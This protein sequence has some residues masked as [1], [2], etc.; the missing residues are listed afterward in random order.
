MAKYFCNLNKEKI[1]RLFRIRDKC[2]LTTQLE[3]IFLA[4]LFLFTRNL[5][6][7]FKTR[8]QN[9][10]GQGDSDKYKITSKLEGV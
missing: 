3:T 1:T 2:T 6:F 9:F 4:N 5:A 10:G 8:L 7:I